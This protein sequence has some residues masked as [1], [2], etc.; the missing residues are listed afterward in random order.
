MKLSL[1]LGIQSCSME[2]KELHIELVGCQDAF[3]VWAYAYVADVVGS[4]SHM[5]WFFWRPRLNCWLH[6][7][8]FDS[9]FSDRKLRWQYVFRICQ[10]EGFTRRKQNLSNHVHT[11][12]SK[13]FSLFNSKVFFWAL[14]YVLGRS[15]LDFWLKSL[16]RKNNFW[17]WS[18]KLPKVRRK[19][20]KY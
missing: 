9:Q 8:T 15:N 3:F 12:G 5:G 17:T 1:F 16:I 19:Y 11:R 2:N 14:D 10:W 18:F 7:L 13:K 6:S 20:L 4:V